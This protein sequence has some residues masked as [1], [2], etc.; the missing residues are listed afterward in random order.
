ME[1]TK[2]KILDDDEPYE[3]GD[4]EDTWIMFPNKGW[5]DYGYYLNYRL[6]YIDKE[7][8]LNKIGE[9]HILPEKVENMYSQPNVKSEELGECI[10]IGIDE[11]YYSNIKKF[12]SGNEFLRKI[13]DITVCPESLSDMLEKLHDPQLAKKVSD[14]SSFINFDNFYSFIIKVFLL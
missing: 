14:H 13:R 6:K 10:S 7:K 4:E 1:N 8:K 12:E 11:N 9:L 2:I 5:N 3:Y